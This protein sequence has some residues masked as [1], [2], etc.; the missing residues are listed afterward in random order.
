M[1]LA[2]I[3]ARRFRDLVTIKQPP[4]AEASQDAQGQP[5]GAWTR[6]TD[7]WAEI[8]PTA[9]D[10]VFLGDRLLGTV[11]HTITTRYDASILASMRVEFD[12]RTFLIA[13]P[14]NPDGL[15]MLT[16]FDAIELV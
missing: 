12:G 11:S 15:K 7:V 5:A 4:S 14:R 1:P 3:N 10:E 2:R 8:L 13:A 6:L 16:E 9:G